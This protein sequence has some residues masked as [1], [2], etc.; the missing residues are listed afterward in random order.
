MATNF[1]RYS[2]K[3][4]GLAGTYYDVALYKLTSPTVAISGLTAL[5]TITNKAVGTFAEFDEISDSGWYGIGVRVYGVGSYVAQSEKWGFWIQAKPPISEDSSLV[6]GNITSLTAVEFAD[7]YQIYF[8]NACVNK[9]SYTY[10]A[11]YCFLTVGTHTGWGIAVGA[12][13]IS[14]SGSVPTDITINSIPSV[15]YHKEV[16]VGGSGIIHKPSKL[17]TAVSG[18]QWDCLMGKYLYLSIWAKNSAGTYVL[19]SMPTQVIQ[20]VN[21]AT[22]Y[23]TS[24]TSADTD[25]PDAI[26]R[27]A[28]LESKCAPTSLDGT[29]LAV[30]TVAD[31]GEFINVLVNADTIPACYYRY[32][33][34]YKIYTSTY[35]TIDPAN[36]ATYDAYVDS[37][38][39][40][41]RIPKLET[42]GTK[43][44][45]VCACYTDLG[46][47][48]TSPTLSVNTLTTIRE[49]LSRVAYTALSGSNIYI[50]DS[51]VINVRYSDLTVINSGRMFRLDYA[52]NADND[53]DWN[54]V[55]DALWNTSNVISLYNN[56]PNFN[57][58][59]DMSTYIAN[60][61]DGKSIY[62]LHIR[63]AS[64]GANGI[65]TFAAPASN[66]LNLFGYSFIGGQ[67]QFVEEL[68]NQIIAKTQTSEGIKL[69][70]Q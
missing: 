16:I 62:Y 43:N 41:V 68:L 29:Y 69:E 47:K 40:I 14:L 70:R 38:A 10:E 61:S 37:D 48:L 53:T 50:T 7:H 45:A 26:T 30:P 39:P 23:E 57:I 13:V 1:S 58:Q 32:R 59:K 67:A 4:G 36:S 44:I 6:A 27:I 18:I 55:T 31:E 5:Q 3:V 20:R 21:M 35:A 65:S 34:Y 51:N 66:S 12:P 25:L 46:G 28:D 11:H 8:S 9:N 24:R 17:N 60:V 42:F 15:F 52:I 33:V 22:A 63:M 2:V 49:S 64:L 56:V 19:T 54:S